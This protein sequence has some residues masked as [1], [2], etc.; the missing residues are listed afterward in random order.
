MT[1]NWKQQLQQKMDS[2]EK[3]APELSWSELDKAL[4]ARAANPQA[5]KATIVPLWTKRI[6]TAA[7]VALIAI[8]GT[9]L[10]FISE[11][12][13][14]IDS[15]T[16]E[17]YTSQ[18]A[19]KKPISPL[20]ERLESVRELAVTEKAKT[21]ARADTTVPSTDTAEKTAVELPKI[22]ETGATEETKVEKKVQEKAT[23][24]TQTANQDYRYMALTEQ[25]SYTKKRDSHR[26]FAADLHVQ[27]LMGAN[28]SGNGVGTMN[29]LMS[30]APT[31]SNGEMQMQG[32]AYPLMTT[33][34]H[35]LSYDHDLPIKIG[36]SLRYNIDERWSIVTGVNY[37]YLH[38]TFTVND[39]P[40]HNGS[41]KLHYIGI[42]VSASLNIW[43]NDQLKLYITAGGTAEKLLKGNMKETTPG[44]VTE[45]TKLTESRLQ[46]SMQGAAGVEYNITPALGLY[47]EPG[48]S[49]HF[50][51]HSDIQNIYKEKPWNFSLNLGF[52]LN[53]K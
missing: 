1:E 48:V 26:G 14:S 52:R 30:D 33:K 2:L 4:K 6:A 25:P 43:Q 18:Q 5:R 19:D 45:E 8:A 35:D 53:I 12:G 16:Q 7:A 17:N 28:N 42:P 32:I 40:D 49:H 3:P 47:V 20:K 10:L 36:V 46:W 24:K 9:R 29:L 38:S 13:N 21:V 37:S 34:R 41:Q 11:E 23:R 31:Y 44:D 39:N 51:N 50:N 27:G 22:E 15:N